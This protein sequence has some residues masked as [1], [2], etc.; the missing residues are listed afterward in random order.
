MN[1][2]A[3]LFFFAVHWFLI[4]L[5]FLLNLLIVMINLTWWL[6]GKALQ[7]IDIIMTSLGSVRILLLSIYLLGTLI[8]YFIA[9]VENSESHLSLIIVVM[10]VVFCSLWWGTVLGVFY[11]VKITTYRNH[12]FMRLKMNISSMVPWMLI[13]SMVISMI[14]S[15]PC[16]W[17]T[18]SVKF[19]HIDS[20][21]TS[22]NDGMPYLKIQHLNL[23]LITFAGSI[24]PLLIFCVSI[25]LLIASVLKHTRN[26]NSN[27]SEFSKP[28]MEAHKSALITMVSFLFFYLLYFVNSNLLILSL[29]IKKPIFTYLCSVGV[30]SYPSLHSIIL[31]ASNVKLKRSIISALRAILTIMFSIRMCKKDSLV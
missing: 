18:Y 26:M 5:G 1:L 22:N 23:M 30:S 21:N 15:L 31:I 7:S 16:L 13:G 25:Y 3:F 9:P 20:G 10:S 11:C 29:H 12:L 4:F 24:L 28:Q 2:I 27:N 17:G 19:T 8:D 6:K 14:S